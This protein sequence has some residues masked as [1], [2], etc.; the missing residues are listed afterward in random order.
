M[1]AF[2]RLFS[3]LLTSFWFASVAWAG[4]AGYSFDSID[5]GTID[6]GDWAGR[7]V[8]VVN[9]AS[10]CAFTPQYAELQALYD[11]YKAQGL[12]VLAVPSDDFRQ[13]L[14]SSEEV[15]AFCEL[16]FGLDMPMTDITHVR[17]AKAHPFYAGVKAE[18]GF[19]PGWNFHKVLIG[20]DGQVT[21]TWGARTRPMSAE[22]TGVIEGLL[23]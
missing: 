13:E 9:T 5:G 3:A 6:T 19:V 7:P 17:G 16:T 23:N 22:V 20:P 2:A 10:Q 15:K 4:M 14:N 12:V 8:L 11:R 21:A 18:T 1:R